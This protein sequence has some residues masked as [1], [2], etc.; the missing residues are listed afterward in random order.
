MSLEVVAVGPGATLQDAGRPGMGAIGVPV[1]GA[2]DRAAAARANRLVGNAA[3]AVVLETVLASFAL[4]ADRRHVVVLTGAPAEARVD[5]R[6]A[7]LG[8]PFALHAGQTLTVGMPVAGLRT[9]LAVQGGIR[10]EQVLG[11]AGSSPGL[12]PGPVRPGQ[13]L[14]V[15]TA[16]GPSR[17]DDVAAAEDSWGLATARVVLGPRDDWFTRAAIGHLLTTAWRASSE[18]DRVGVRLDGPALDRSRPGELASEGLVRGAVQVPADGRP[19][20]FL[21]D[22]PTTGG[23]PVVAVVVDADVDRLAQLRPGDPVRFTPV[24]APWR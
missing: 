16:N 19:L 11:S 17:P 1:G 15:L 7:P 5:G 12:G 13:V 21:A 3:R 24:T 18:L 2:A 9:Y 20:V 6:P 23:Y 8:E 10:A 22:A 4:R 14:E